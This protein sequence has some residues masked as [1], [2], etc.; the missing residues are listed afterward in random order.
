M[1]DILTSDNVSK[2]FDKCMFKKGEPTEGFIQAEGIVNKFGFNPE[3]LEES[4][5]EIESMLYELPDEFKSSSG[6]GWSFLNACNDKRGNQWTGLH[7]TMEKLFVLGIAIG[8]VKSLMPRELWTVMP[9][10]MPYYVVLD[11]EEHND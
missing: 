5:N 6:G 9:G 2:V 1:N 3:R 11:K 10:G 4:R 8:K 7:Q